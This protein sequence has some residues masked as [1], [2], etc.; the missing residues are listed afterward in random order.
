MDRG[1][2]MD[3]R[4]K[5]AAFGFLLTILLLVFLGRAVADEQLDEKV[6][7]ALAAQGDVPGITPQDGFVPNERVAVALA[8]A[9]LRPVYGKAVDQQRPLKAKLVDGRWM[10]VGTVKD[11]CAG[12]KKKD[13]CFAVDGGAVRIDIDKSDGRVV[14]ALR[15]R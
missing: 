3:R 11:P 13:K 7:A 4:T 14:R 12:K 10:I 5:P 9:F 1:L 8:E 15:Y 6:M 2:S